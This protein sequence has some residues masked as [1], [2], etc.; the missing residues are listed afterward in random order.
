MLIS[1]YYKILRVLDWWFFISLGS[2]LV[3]TFC[4]YAFRIEWLL[5][6]TRS[7]FAEGVK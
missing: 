7:P 5:W 6:L 1:N 2:L 4:A 3:A